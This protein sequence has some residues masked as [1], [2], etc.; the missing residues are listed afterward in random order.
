M[1]LHEET[2]NKNLF[3]I[4]ILKATVFSF[5]SFPIGSEKDFTKKLAYLKMWREGFTA[6]HT[7]MTS[8]P[9][10][11]PSRSQSVQIIRRVAALASFSKVR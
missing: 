3:H 8:N 7:S 2:N 11:S 6:L 9:M 4:N 10:F 1:V 5:F